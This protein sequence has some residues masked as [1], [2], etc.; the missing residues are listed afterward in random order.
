[1][2]F[3]RLNIKGLL[4]ASVISTGANMTL[5]EKDRAFI[6]VIKAT[7]ASKT[8]TLDLPDDACCI[9]LNGGSNTFTLKNVSGDTGTSVAS[10]GVYLVKASQTA[11]GT[12][13]VQLVADGSNNSPAA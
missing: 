6:L 13:A 3:T 11:N 12:A 4:G 8:V 7:A 1:M 9:V 2:D 5:A 10:G